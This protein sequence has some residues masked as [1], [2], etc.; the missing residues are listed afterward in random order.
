[1]AGK[2]GKSIPPFSKIVSIFRPPSAPE[3]VR[4]LPETSNG[5][6]PGL[7]AFRAKWK[8]RLL[9]D[10]QSVH[11]SADYHRRPPAVAHQTDDAVAADPLR[12]LEPERPQLLRHPFGALLFA[13]GELGVTVQVGVEL[14]G[15]G[16][17]R[18]S[19]F[20][21]LRRPSPTFPPK[22]RTAA[23][24]SIPKC[25]PKAVFFA[26]SASSPQ[27]STLCNSRFRR[28]SRRV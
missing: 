9:L 27:A 5:Q 26:S 18:G 11:V 6:P 14:A 20:P 15:R 28:P 16:S 13:E 7:S 8:P 19:P 3:R 23:G 12:H 10:G 25:F 24:R 22:G 2:N 21:A 17:R 1:M 4:P